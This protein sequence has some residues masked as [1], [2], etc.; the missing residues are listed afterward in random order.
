[1][2]KINIKF[3]WSKKLKRLK[4]KSRFKVIYGGRDGTKSTT[5]AQWFIAAALKEKIRVLCCREVLKSIEKSVFKLF[6][7]IIITN[8][9]S[10]FFHITQSSIKCILTDSEFMFAGIRNDPEQIKSTEG[11]THVWIEESAGITDT[12]F[13]ILQ[14]TVRRTLRVVQFENDKL[15][16]KYL[17]EN[18]EMDIEEYVDRD[19]L[20]VDEP[21]EIWITFNPDSEDDYVFKRFVTNKPD[22]CILININYWDNGY[23]SAS[24]KKD[25]EDMKRNDYGSYLHVYCGLPR[26][27]GKLIYAS[28]FDEK[29]HVLQ[30]SEAEIL[31]K[32]AL[33]G[34]AFTGM[35]PHLTYL[36]FIV[37][38]AMVPTETRDQFDYIVYNEWPTVEYCG[39]KYYDEIR[40]TKKLD[41]PLKTLADIILNLDGADYGIQIVNRFLDTRFAKASGQES[42]VTESKGLIETLRQPHNGG[43][44]W[45]CPYEK[46]IDVQRVEILN[47]LDYNRMAGISPLNRPTMY[48]APWCKNT[49][50]AV[51]NHRD[52]LDK[53]KEDPRYKDPI[54]AI[55]ICMAGMKD[56]VFVEKREH[57]FIPSRGTWAA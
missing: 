56:H 11:L 21:P 41:I 33:E 9:L 29:I 38:V 50:R 44:Y 26:G 17:I 16:D 19:K 18:P 23:L 28:K 52:D 31:E 1:M 47:R 6:H 45:N 54:D 14:P 15:L 43:L 46:I 10:Q 2:D 4:C 35:D 3:R 42:I 27:S 55:R 8:D 51:K 22:N 40:Q 24:S 48:F 57:Y 32:I 25:I 53:N 36:P 13:K 49:I 12:S 7:D 37:W 5:V 20:T 30:S 34:A 39:G